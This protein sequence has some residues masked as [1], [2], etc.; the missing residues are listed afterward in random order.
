MVGF[1]DGEGVAIMPQDYYVASP[2]GE[3]YINV[4]VGNRSHG[5]DKYKA[6]YHR[7]DILKLAWQ[8]GYAESAIALANQ[9]KTQLAQATQETA[10]PLLPSTPPKRRL[11]LVIGNAAYQGYSPLKN[12]VNDATDLAAV[13]KTLNFEVIEKHNL[14]YVEMEE[15]I[16][17]FDEKYVKTPAW[18]YS[19][20]QGMAC[21]IKEPIT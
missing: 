15:A 12:P 21:N 1:D 4:S 3:Q 2:K 20:S 11:A 16:L 6:F 7:P 17:E 9:Q 13:L 14:N 18:V 19:I 5:I 10:Q 8:L